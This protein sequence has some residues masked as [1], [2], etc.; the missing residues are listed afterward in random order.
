MSEAERPGT[1]PPQ[2]RNAP[3]PDWDPD[4]VDLAQ[5]LVA[6]AKSSRRSRTGGRSGSSSRRATGS[7]QRYR[8]GAGWSG[9]ADDDR[10]PQAL[11]AAVERLV[12]EHGW[13][14]DLAVH[15]VVAR[16][17]Q[18]VGADVAAHV[19]PER[20]ADTVL[21]VRADS[22]AW[23]TQVRLLAPTIVRRLNEEIGD[24]VVSKVAVLGPHAPSWRKGPR[25]VP[26]RGPRDTYG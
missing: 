4:G 25:S 21:T 23:A 16:W 8:E 15:G 20:Y 7:G 6:R 13:G 2:G 19:R 11:D 5:S 17:D 14:E 12:G 24:G 18:I 1:E 3:E 26:G 9:P 22:T 10:D